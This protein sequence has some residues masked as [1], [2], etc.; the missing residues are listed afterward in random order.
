MTDIITIQEAASLLDYKDCRSVEAWCVRNG[1][2][3]MSDGGKKR[4]ML[5][6]QFEAARLKKFIEHLKVRY[7][8]NWLHAFE[9]YTSMNITQVVTLEEAGSM[10]T[11]HSNYKPNGQAEKD[12][13]EQFTKKLSTL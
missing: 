6:M 2:V 1:V 7:K 3:L 10:R 12:C 9:T 13:L 11:I 4:Y 5:R 8:Q